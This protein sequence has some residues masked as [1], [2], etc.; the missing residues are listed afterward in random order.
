MFLETKKKK[1]III[2][3]ILRVY[4]DLRNIL[5]IEDIV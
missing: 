2:I 1:I 3:Y 5:H 4:D